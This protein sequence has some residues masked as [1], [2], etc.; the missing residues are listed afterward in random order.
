M[1]LNAQLA[2]ETLVGLD[3]TLAVGEG[4]HLPADVPMT[5]RPRQ[6]RPVLA[7]ALLLAA[8]GLPSARG[9][10]A[11]IDA[12]TGD[13]SLH[14]LAPLLESHCYDCHGYGAREGNLALDELLTAEPS[15][16]TRD[17]WRKTW[18]MVRQEF[19]PPVGAEPLAH[20]ARK[21]LTRAIAE[22]RLGVD[23]AKPDPGRVTMRRLNRMEYDF[24]IRDLFGVDVTTSA[25]VP[26]MTS[27]SETTLRDL[28]PPDDTAFGFDNI[29]DFQSLPPA[30]LDRYFEIAELVVS[31]VIITEGPWYPT[32]EVGRERLDVDR[33]DEPKLTRHVAKFEVDRAGHYQVQ[34]SFALGGWQEYGG[35]YDYSFAVDGKQASAETIDVGGQEVHEYLA[36]QDFEPGEHEVVLTTV[37]VK[38]NSDGDLEHLR[39]NA[40]VG[41]T[42][43]IVEGEASYPESHRKIFFDGPAPSDPEQRRAYAEA[44]LKRVS[45]RAF[46]RPVDP[47]TLGRLADLALLDDN[48]ER[49]VGQAMVAILTS[50]RFLFRTEMQPQPD[51]PK[52]VHAIDEYALASRLSY[53]LWLSLPDEEL[54]QLAADGK[55]RENLPAQLTRMLADPKSARF[56]EDFAGQWLRTRNVLM[57]AI[58]KRDMIDPYRGAL[59]RETDMMFEHIVREDRDL[60]E[61]VT[62]DYTFMNR[63]LA[64]FYGL[65][66][67]AE[68]DDFERVEL[69]ADSHRGG[70]LTQGSFLT[71]TSNPD[72]TSPVKRGLFV[73]ENLL[74]TQPPPPPANVPPLDDAHVE[75]K[76]VVSV[77]DQLEAHRADPACAAC[78]AHFDPIGIVLENYDLVGKWR[79]AERS[80][81][82]IDPTGVTVTG[83]ELAGIDDLKE[84]IVDNKER[85]YRCCTEK[86]MTYALGRGIEPYDAATVDRITDEMMADGGKF[87]TLLISVVESPAFQTRRGDDASELQTAPRVVVPEIPPPDKR[88]GRRGRFNQ[89][90]R[91]G[92][93][94][95]RDEQR[96]PEPEA[97][98]A[99]DPEAKESNDE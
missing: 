53:L 21:T 43:P 26:S 55:L 4:T 24:T 83:D 82:A 25:H 63:Q 74:A 14:T 65:R 18:K 93:R 7:G 58:S 99:V 27:N 44:V 37:A 78:H 51:D 35:A 75:G 73:L 5:L 69:P 54:T 8:F 70:L 85:F 71:S 20:D 50:P 9:A 98:V 12:S 47:V 38:A 19:M 76:M 68:G 40:R 10:D 72:R 95:G 32:Q 11:A 84:Y 17:Q 81:A 46:R 30:L 39:L 16:A 49:G 41:V 97:P 48:F 88:K 22:S 64:R 52:A 92:E 89:F 67:I 13:V 2:F 79:E 60:L 45:D 86:L 6:P 42:G 33:E 90:Q 23:Y 66:G 15:P 77:R 57:T 61:L 1:R 31:N 80:G 91:P 29:G 87:S 34:V 3:S 36:V 62:A 59:K 56:L 96:R 28:L 94:R